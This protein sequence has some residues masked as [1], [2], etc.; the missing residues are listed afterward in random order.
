MGGIWRKVN[1]VVNNGPYP[2][3]YSPCWVTEK[4]K[5]KE[6]YW[7]SDIECYGIENDERAKSIPH[8]GK[9]YFESSDIPVVR[10]KKIKEI[11]T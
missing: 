4:W 10:D 8:L 6:K 3:T 1:I 5:T 9:S 11:L 2:Y 7:V